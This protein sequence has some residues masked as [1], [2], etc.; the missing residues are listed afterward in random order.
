MLDPYCLDFR[1]QI[2]ADLSVCICCGNVGVGLL[3][4]PSLSRNNTF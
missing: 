4:F 2:Q 1:A 3:E